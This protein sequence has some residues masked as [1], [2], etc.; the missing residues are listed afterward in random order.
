[1]RAV[2]PSRSALTLDPMIGSVTERETF[3]VCVRCGRPVERNRDQYETFERMHWSCF[4]YEFEHEMAGSGDPDIACND[5][6]CPARAFDPIPQLPGWWPEYWPSRESPRL[7]R[8][9]KQQAAEEMARIFHAADH[10]GLVLWQLNQDLGLYSG[11]TLT[12][13]IRVGGEPWLIKL[14]LDDDG[15]VVWIF[16][17][18]DRV[19][20]RADGTPARPT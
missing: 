8:M 16:A 4:H 18:E 13:S 2:S 11:A 15:D 20:V 10:A 3:P 1:M 6:A 9:D 19:V 14:G 7:G 5:P 17:D 12:F